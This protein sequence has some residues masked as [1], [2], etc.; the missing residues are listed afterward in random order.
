MN[1]KEKLR[2]EPALDEYARNKLRAIE[3][4]IKK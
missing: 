1:T 3:N 4:E 2:E